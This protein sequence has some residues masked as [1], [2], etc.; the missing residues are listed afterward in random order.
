[1]AVL[2]DEQGARDPEPQEV[3]SLPEATMTTGTRWLAAAA[4]L[5]A[6]PAAAQEKEALPE[7]THRDVR[8][9]PHPT[10][11]VLDLWLAKSDAPT[12]IL[13]S[14]HHGGFSQG[15]K[16]VQPQLL[17]ECL[18]A[19]ISVAAINYR[20]TEQAIAPAAF[21]DAA[22]AV[23]FLRHRAADWNL[24]ADRVAAAG[25]SSGGGISLWLAFHDDLADPTN[26]DPV[27]RHSTRLR[28]A[29]GFNAQTSYDPRFIRTLFPGQEVHKVQNLGYLF[30]VDLDRIDDLPAE[31]YRLFEEV[32]P[33]THLTPDDPPVLLSY[34]SAF[35]AKVT[36][37]GIGIHH[38]RFGTVLAEKMAAAKVPCELS[39]DGQRHGGGDPVPTINFLKTHL[40]RKP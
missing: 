7:P 18:A 36:T 5:I 2:K 35:D 10:K 11:N 22:R 14:I 34:K 12:P 17:K 15:Q 40:A 37:P 27:L 23:Q 19:G 32:S 29:A 8:Y 4:L 30:R 16:F 20:L 21:H 28:C 9:G 26:A 6:V 1:V 25:G 3:N 38:P 24:D 31:K 13:V 39:A 33:L